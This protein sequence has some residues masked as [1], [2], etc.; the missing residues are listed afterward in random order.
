MSSA[1]F[2]L[3][4]APRR[5]HRCTEPGCVIRFAL[6]AGLSSSAGVARPGR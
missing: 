3:E 5:T 4:G 2:D 1:I 6:F